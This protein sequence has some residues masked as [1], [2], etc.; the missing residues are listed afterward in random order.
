MKLSNKVVLIT[1]ASA[2]IG[3]ATALAFDQ[4]G[5]RVAITARRK[6]KLD[7]VAL[8]LHDP[9]VLTADLSDEREAR[10]IIGQTIA[11][12]GR[13]DILIN[14]AASII[15]TPVDTVSPG[16][17]AHCIQGPILLHRL[18]PSRRLSLHMSKNGGGPDH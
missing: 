16:G 13:I 14:N 18:Q 7:Q 10:Q 8:S 15:V 4:A 6:E 9:L 5:A 3:A 17:H 1:G 12:F 2:G 11:R